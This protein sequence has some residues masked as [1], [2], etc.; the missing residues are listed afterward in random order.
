MGKRKVS[1]L[2]PAVTAVAEI[3]LFIESEGLP[4][5]AKSLLMMLFCFLQ[6][7][8]MKELNISHAAISD[9]KTL[10][11]AVSLTKRN[12]LLPISARKKK[13][14]SVILLPQSC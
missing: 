1:I 3:A 5:T 10:T 14:L 4:Q 13:L 8:L 9:G 6:N 2:E 11:I 7:S 12:M